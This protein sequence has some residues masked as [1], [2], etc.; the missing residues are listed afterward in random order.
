MASVLHALAEGDNCPVSSLVKKT[1]LPNGTL[2]GL[3]DALEED[4]R[5]ERTDNPRDG[6][7]WIIRLT[8]AG[9][10]FCARLEERHKVVMSVF[11]DALTE[12]E[13]AE[14]RRL[15]EKTTSTMRV[16]VGGGVAAASS[17]RSRK[18]VP[19]AP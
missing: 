17:R 7:S 19:K 15:L 16:H 13:A 18:P 2:T 8:P 1:Q 3:L 4:G 11:Q 10:A 14:L 5:I 9:R 12:E 6:R